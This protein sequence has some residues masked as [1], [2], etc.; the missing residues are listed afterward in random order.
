MTTD[1]GAH[2]A[3]LALS[4]EAFV[5]LTTFRKTGAPVSTPVWI[6][7]YGNY[8]VVTTPAESGKVKRL[9][10]NGQVE[11]RPCDR[12][13]KVKPG[14]RAVEGVAGILADTESVERISAVFARKYRLEY[15]I[16]MLIE[17]LGKSG[18]K[19]RVILRITAP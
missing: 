5:S 12:M 6:A 3:L 15:R 18:R 19:P 4:D 16:F 14:A 17:R 7:R 13:G 8:L 9:R 10:N 11:L 1:T 2:A